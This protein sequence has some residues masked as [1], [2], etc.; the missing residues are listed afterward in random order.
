MHATT[1]KGKLYLEK[2]HNIRNHVHN[3]ACETLNS[4][5]TH[6]TGPFFDRNYTL[7]IHAHTKLL[8]ECISLKEFRIDGEPK[9]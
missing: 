1:K 4:T 9:E 2:V 7:G 5:N 3:K 6:L 8:A